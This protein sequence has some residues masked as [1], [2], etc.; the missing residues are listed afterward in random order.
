MGVYSAGEVWYNCLVA[1]ASCLGRVSVTTA[2]RD[3]LSWSHA[4]IF[5]A[6]YDAG[7]TFA[8]TTLLLYVRQFSVQIV[9][10]SYL[11]KEDKSD[12]ILEQKKI[13]IIRP[14]IACFGTS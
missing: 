12:R 10:K 11:S 2:R 3:R 6:I 5:D 7:C 13:P 8:T 14:K 9:D 1:T 4:D